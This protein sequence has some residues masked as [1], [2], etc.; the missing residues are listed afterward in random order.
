MG[1]ATRS[2]PATRMSEN[3][4]DRDGLAGRCDDD[5]D[6][7]GDDEVEVEREERRPPCT[8]EH[9]SRSTW[10][11]T[12]RTIVPRLSIRVVETQTQSPVLLVPPPPSPMIRVPL[13]IPPPPSRPRTLSRQTYPPQSA[14]SCVLFV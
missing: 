8:L 12:K 7:A 5:D 1:G 11:L 3:D 13:I 4:K 6:D 14:L 10:P 2:R 9:R